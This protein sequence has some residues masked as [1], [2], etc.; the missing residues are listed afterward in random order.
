MW[1]TAH[2]VHLCQT[3]KGYWKAWENGEGPG[4]TYSYS[5]SARIPSKGLGDSLERALKTLGITQD[6]YVEVKEMFGL[7]PTCN[8]N[9]RREWL[10]KV[11]RWISGN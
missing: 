7:P 8:C 1:K 9:A 11:G 3:N 4:Q 10:N 2:W 6:R 5:A